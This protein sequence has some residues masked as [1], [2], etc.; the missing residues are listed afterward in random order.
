[1]NAYPNAPPP[2]MAGP[3][4]DQSD[5]KLLSIF[6]YVWSAFLGC[7]TLGMIGYFVMLG[8]IFAAAP[9]S[10]GANP[11]G[12]EVAAGVMVVMGVVIALFTV[13]LFILHLMA[14]S[15]LRNQKRYVL[16]LVMSGFACLSVP[17]GTALGIWTIMT[18]QRPGV[19][20]LF[21]RT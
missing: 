2:M 8:G 1:M 11:E 20:S 3:S 15:G 7:G 16:I 10:P 12:Q 13:P 5:L 18:L 4:K 6:H 17:L 19:K 9:A 21:G 14:A